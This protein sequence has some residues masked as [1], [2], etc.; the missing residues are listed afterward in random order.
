MVNPSTNLS[1]LIGRSPVVVPHGI[2]PSEF[3]PQEGSVYDSFAVGLPAVIF[4]NGQFYPL[5]S[6]ELGFLKQQYSQ[7]L[8][9]NSRG[10]PEAM[11]V[12]PAMPSIPDQIDDLSKFEQ[13][14]ER[15]AEQ[16]PEKQSEQAETPQV[17][18]LQPTKTASIIP[19]S[20][21]Q[22]ILVDVNRVLSTGKDFVS[23]TTIDASYK[24]FRSGQLSTKANAGKDAVEWLK[25]LLLKAFEEYE[26]ESK[27]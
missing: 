2:L 27:N 20:V 5:T 3:Q 9:G 17:T 7:A 13:S 8:S 14:A 21:P 4:V 10:G 11:P 26:S 18:V 25:L 12:M 22:P 24:K 15:A 16:A 1:F 19:Q 6:E 23:Q